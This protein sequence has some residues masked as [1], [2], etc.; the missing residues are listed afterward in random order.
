MLITFASGKPAT[1]TPQCSP[2]PPP[3]I[4]GSPSPR[5]TPPLQALDGV[6][7]QP[8]PPPAARVQSAH[9][10]GQRPRGSGATERVC[11]TLGDCTVFTPS[12]LHR[13]AFLLPTGIG[14]FT[15]LHRK[16]C[17]EII[18]VLSASDSIRTCHT[19]FQ[20]YPPVCTPFLHPLIFMI[21]PLPSILTGDIR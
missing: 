11:V 13:L 20:V 2:S 7:A 6:E 8:L 21:A 16:C 9:T 14:R 19:L 17:S 3:W 1:F 12:R 5:V 4:P 15:R 10:T 18:Y